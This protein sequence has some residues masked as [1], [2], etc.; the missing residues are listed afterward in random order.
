VC[1]VVGARAIAPPRHPR[2]EDARGV[3]SSRGDRRRRAMG[4]YDDLPEV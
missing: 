3:D 2:A 1:G 4:L